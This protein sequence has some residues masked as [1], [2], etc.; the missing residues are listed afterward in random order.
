MSEKEP[1]PSVKVVDRRWWVK[2]DAASAGDAAAAPASLKPTYV[3]QLEQQLAEKDRQAQEYLGK[4]RQAAAEFDDARLRLRR[5][6]SKDVE[7]ARRDVIAE[8]LEIV[9][10][11]ERALDAGRT[12]PSA[13]A[14]LQGV[15]MVHRQFLNKLE[16]LGVKPI[17]SVSRPFDPALHEAITTVPAATADQDGLVVGVVRQGYTI[18][19][20]VLRPAA[21]AVAKAD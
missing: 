2:N 19:G 20:D 3:E 11:L 14:L 21:V 10:N 12:S 6:I 18:G 5:E 9:D 8:M 4:Y 13:D 15:E 1:E 17:A 7:R 16:S